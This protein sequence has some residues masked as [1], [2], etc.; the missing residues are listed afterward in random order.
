MSEINT[1]G[2]LTR[3]I[4]GEF[5]LLE[6]PGDTHDPVVCEL[7]ERGKRRLSEHR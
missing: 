1:I 5:R 7:T 4:C 2:A 3:G 6:L